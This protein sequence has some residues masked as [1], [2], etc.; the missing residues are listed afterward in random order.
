MVGTASDYSY[1]ENEMEAMGLRPISALKIGPARVA[2]SLLQFE[3]VLEDKLEIGTGEAGSSTLVVGR[4]VQIHVSPEVY[5]NG[6]IILERYQPV[7]RL[8]GAW[9]C[10]VGNTFEIPIPPRK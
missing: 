5:D 2:D 4:I 7:A 8:G 10:E 6:R 1:G 3:C 9:Y